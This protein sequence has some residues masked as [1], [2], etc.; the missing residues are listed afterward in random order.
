MDM[1]VTQLI[2]FGEPCPPISSASKSDHYV[3][4]FSRDHSITLEVVSLL[5]AVI[6]SQLI[7]DDVISKQ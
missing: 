7:S 2:I 6:Q 3:V 5:K 1:L 4:A